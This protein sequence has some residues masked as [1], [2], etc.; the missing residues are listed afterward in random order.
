[1]CVYPLWITEYNQNVL[2]TTAWELVLQSWMCLLFQNCFFQSGHSPVYHGHNWCSPGVHPMARTKQ[3]VAAPLAPDSLCGTWWRGRWDLD[4]R[5]K[6]LLLS[7]D[8]WIFFIRLCQTNVEVNWG[9]WPWKGI[10]RDSSLITLA[11]GN[12]YT[13]FI[14]AH[15][16][17]AAAW[18]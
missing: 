13:C 16:P 15:E 1:M 12:L 14:L 17:P 4:E 8:S 3:Q 5:G 10:G 6:G 9:D 2:R 18:E 11:T 7:A